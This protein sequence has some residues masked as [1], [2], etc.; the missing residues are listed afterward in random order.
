MPRM[1]DKDYG[2][3]FLFLTDPAQIESRTKLLRWLIFEDNGGLGLG[4]DV[5]YNM[6]FVGANDSTNSGTPTDRAKAIDDPN[7]CPFMQIIR[8]K[9]SLRNVGR[10]YRQTW[11]TMDECVAEEAA[12]AADEA[13]AG[14]I[15]PLS[16]DSRAMRVPEVYANYFAREG[17]FK[18]LRICLPL[19]Q[20]KEGSKRVDSVIEDQ[21]SANDPTPHQVQQC[22][23]EKVFLSSDLGACD[24]N[25]PSVST[26]EEMGEGS[27]TASNASTNASNDLAAE[28]GDGECDAPGI[29]G[30]EYVTESANNHV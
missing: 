7:F 29:I 20:T 19:D 2:Q 30:K 8:D 24:D 6:F 21:I 12:T 25:I 23:D 1:F 26:D 13:F 3:A 10:V 16:L 17:E 5:V 28:W 11:N 14:R 27:C 15:D 4:V 22:Q 18:R 9:T